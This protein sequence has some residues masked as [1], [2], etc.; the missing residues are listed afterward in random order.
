[1]ERVVTEADYQCRDIVHLR[2]YTTNTAALFG[3]GGA[4]TCSPIG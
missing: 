4:S 2:L 1:V 3:E